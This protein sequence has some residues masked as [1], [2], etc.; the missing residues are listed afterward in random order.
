MTQVIPQPVGPLTQAPDRL[1]DPEEE[2]ARLLLI[3]LYRDAR[4]SVQRIAETM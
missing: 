4:A 2:A 1:D 3:V